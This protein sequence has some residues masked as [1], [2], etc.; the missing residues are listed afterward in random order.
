M[1]ACYRPLTLRSPSE[2]V[3]Y[4]RSGNPY[5]STGLQAGI[6]SKYLGFPHRATSSD[7]AVVSCVSASETPRVRVRDINFS[8]AEEL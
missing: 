5:M 1:E 7:G 6:F 3:L 2:V 4:T 8:D